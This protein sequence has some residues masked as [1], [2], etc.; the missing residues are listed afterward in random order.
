MTEINS[1]EE[2]GG[3]CCDTSTPHPIFPIC[4]PVKFGKLKLWLEMDIFER[5]VTQD[6]E[7]NLLKFHIV[8]K[9]EMAE[10]S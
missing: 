7:I 5:N 9:T 6:S 3:A 8:S 2:A 10:F 4:L 1:T